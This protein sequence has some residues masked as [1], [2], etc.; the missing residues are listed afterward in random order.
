MIELL[1]LGLILGLTIWLLMRKWDLGLVLLLDTLLVSA[2][3]LYPPAALALSVVRGLVAPQTLNLAG[4]VFLVLC[5]AELLRRTKAMERMVASIQVLVPDSRIVL[6]LV[7]AFIGLMPM[8]GG[9]MFS[10]PMINS[11]GTPLNLS[12]HRKTF[13]NYW[14]RHTMEYVFPLYSSI[15]VLVALLEITPYAFIRRA[16]P[17][18]LAAI[19]GGIIWGLA[20][21][22]RPARQADPAAGS[23]RVDAPWRGLLASTWPLL[24]VIL[25]VVIL[26]LNMLLSLAGVIVLTAITKRIGPAQWLDVL[27]HSFPLHTFSAIFAVMVFKHVIEDAGAVQTIPDAL[28]S[29]GLPPLLVA[30]V[31]PHLAGLLTGTAP[32]AMALGVPLVMP[33]M[34]ALNVDYA[35]SG[36]WLFAGAFTGVLLSPLHLCLSLTRAYFEANWGKLYRAVVPATALVIATALGIILWTPKA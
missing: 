18:S 14:F 9:A 23:S 25:L 21:L 17:L 11:I 19:V 28:S 30:F 29:L 20:S 10:A 8:L 24:L 4:A 27:R 7:P 5:L 36:V 32:A 6:A 33:L 34:N 3:F 2:L 13:V 1:K 35:A 22:P 26:K 31:I 12:P 16:Y 15:L